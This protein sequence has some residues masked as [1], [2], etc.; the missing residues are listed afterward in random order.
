MKE[1]EMEM[2]NI[3]QEL[4]KETIDLI[5]KEEILENNH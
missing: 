2:K 4:K 3:H 1:F 5:G